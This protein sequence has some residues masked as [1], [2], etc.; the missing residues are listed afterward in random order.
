M[1]KIINLL[2]KMSRASAWFFISI[3]YPLFHIKSTQ[4]CTSTIC[5]SILQF[6]LS[7][8]IKI[9]FI[10]IEVFYIFFSQISYTSTCIKLVTQCPFYTLYGLYKVTMLHL[11]Y[12]SVNNQMVGHRQCKAN[13]EIYT[14]ILCCYK[15]L[16]IY[17]P[18]EKE[19]GSAIVN[20]S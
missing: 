11:K 9:L 7:V 14:Y 17:Q 13:E 10:A 3:K 1:Q 2:W 16:P 6:H 5:Y 19:V 15:K 18:T 12:W 4:V 20:K 8:L